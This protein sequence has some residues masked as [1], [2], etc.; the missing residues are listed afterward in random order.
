MIM[1]FTSFIEPNQSGSRVSEQEL[2]NKL[3]EWAIG[4]HRKALKISGLWLYPKSTKWYIKI[5]MDLQSPFFAASVIVFFST[6]E[7][8][9]LIRVW[10]DLTLVVDNFLS[11]IPVFSGQIKLLVLWTKRKAISRI[12]NLIENDYLELKND[13]ERKIMIKYAR[14]AKIMMV[15]G[16]ANISYSII[17]FHGSVAFGFLFRTITNLTDIPTHL[18]S[19][20]SVYP[21]DITVGYRCLIIRI[22][23]VILCFITGFYYT[24]IDVFFGI[25]ILHSCGQLKVLAKEINYLT[26][27]CQSSMIKI[28]L[29][30]IVLRHYRII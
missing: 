9:A 1:N 25:S 22:L 30:N 20:Q 17:V 7:I 18:I 15:C 11:F 28:L 24:E 10:S 21:F 19:T 26:D 13:S 27:S 14:I 8:F 2:N 29:K 3:F 4:L 23:H 16:V 6:P 5:L 12:I